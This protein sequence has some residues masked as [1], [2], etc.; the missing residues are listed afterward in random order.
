[1]FN[2]EFVRDRIYELDYTQNDVARMIGMSDSRFASTLKNPGRFRCS[3]VQK[4]AYILRLT[5]VQTY[6]LF[7]AGGKPD[8]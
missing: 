8:D 4:L 6:N 2:L 5:P 7:L 1:M 3:D